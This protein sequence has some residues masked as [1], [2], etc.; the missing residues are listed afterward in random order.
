MYLGLS[1]NQVKIKLNY[2]LLKLH[3]KT[4]NPITQFKK[5]DFSLICPFWENP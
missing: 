2:T 4:Y 3:Y 1:A 5:L